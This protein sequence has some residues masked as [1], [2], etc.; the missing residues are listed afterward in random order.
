[1]LFLRFWHTY[2]SM[3]LCNNPDVQ[4]PLI[5]SKGLSRL[6]HLGH[7]LHNLSCQ[8]THVS[9]IHTS[10]LSLLSITCY[11]ATCGVLSILSITYPLLYISLPHICYENMFLSSKLSILKTVWYCCRLPANIYSWRTLSE[12]VEPEMFL[13]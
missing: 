6:T 12:V 11:F 10:S 7:L 9:S 5:L 4:N 2:S 1:M 13:T 8:I 3:S